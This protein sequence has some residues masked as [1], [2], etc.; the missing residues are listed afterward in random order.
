MNKN[1]CGIWHETISVSEH[2]DNGTCPCLGC[3]GLRCINCKVYIKLANLTYDAY[4]AGRAT[5]CQLCRG[6]KQR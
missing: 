6:I 5:K 3:L 2:N 4:M 1:T